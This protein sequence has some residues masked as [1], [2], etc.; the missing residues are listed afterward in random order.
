MP[1][2]FYAL[3]RH[4]LIQKKTIEIYELTEAGKFVN[5]YG[6]LRDAPMHQTLKEL[7]EVEAQDQSIPQS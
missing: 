6:Y 5:R 7:Y 3:L 4:G 1:I 2:P